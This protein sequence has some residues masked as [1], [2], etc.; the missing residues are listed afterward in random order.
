MLHALALFCI[1][2]VLETSHAAASWGGLARV[3]IAM[4]C[5]GW[6]WFAQKPQAP[7]TAS[8]RTLTVL[9]I[10]LLTLHVAEPRA[11]MY[12]KAENPWTQAF[13]AIKSWAWMFLL[14]ALVAHK[15][16]RRAAVLAG[17]FLAAI[18]A[19]KACVILASPAPEIDVFHVTRQAI[20][21]L[22]DG[23]NPYAQS[24]TNIYEGRLDYPVGFGYLPVALL[25]HTMFD[26]LCGDFRWGYLVAHAA[27]FFGLWKLAPD[28]S[29]K[30]PALPGWIWPCL[31]AALPAGGFVTEQAWIEPW[32]MLG[33]LGMVWAWSRRRWNT[34]AVLA[35]AL[36]AYKQTVW[37]VAILAGVQLVAQQR[38]QAV[39]PLALGVGTFLAGVVPFVAL[40]VDGFFYHTVH[41][42]STYGVRFDALSLPGMLRRA[43]VSNAVLMPAISVLHVL[44][45][46]GL[47]FWVA[48]HSAKLPLAWMTASM[49]MFFVTFGFGHMAF[50]NYYAFLAF[51]ILLDLCCQHAFT[52]HGDTRRS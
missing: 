44:A 13:F 51:L 17:A 4:F 5:V 28:P 41:I 46:V 47:S 38:R 25:V 22:L 39:R 8:V 9:A 36:C 20:G 19:E 43:A 29:P 26:A 6:V 33:V 16:P 2:H 12:A 18:L 10:A 23:K 21:F 3:G 49:L 7:R 1:A 15:T 35:G 32:M 30:A 14:A 48:K 37:I 31:L 34:L 24:Y 52:R 40:D 45:L 50:C 27:L 42:L 11:L